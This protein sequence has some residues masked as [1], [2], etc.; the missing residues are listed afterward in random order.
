MACRG[1]QGRSR[2]A[3]GSSGRSGRKPLL[4]L[5]LLVAGLAAAGTASGDNPIDQKKAEA[6]QVYNQIIQLDQSLSD[7]RIDVSQKL[8]G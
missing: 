7:F 6:Q 8:T 3:T 1:V 2:C 4:L 5:A